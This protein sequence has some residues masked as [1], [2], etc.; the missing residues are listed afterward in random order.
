MSPLSIKK[1]YINYHIFFAMLGTLYSSG[2]LKYLIAELVVFNFVSLPKYN[3]FFNS[4]ILNAR[5]K[6]SLDQIVNIIQVSR[7][8]LILRTTF[9]ENKNNNIK[10]QVIRYK[11]LIL[12]VFFSNRIPNSFK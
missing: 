12:Y 9:K 4:E 5:V 6:Y 11:F 1:K 2:I 10:S 7:I 3:I 8:F